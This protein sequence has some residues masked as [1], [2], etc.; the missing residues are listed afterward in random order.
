MQL[1]RLVGVAVAVLFSLLMT[2]SRAFAQADDAGA[3]PPAATPEPA[4]A[5]GSAPPAGPDAADAGPGTSSTGEPPPA[6]SASS[7]N[8]RATTEVGGYID[9]TATSVLTPSIGLV[10]ESPTA[11]WGVSGRYLVDVVSAASPDIVSTASPHWNEVRQ[12][13][14]LGARYKPGTFGIAVN[15]STSYTPDYLALSAGA[16]L[17]QELDEKNLTLIAGYGYGHD[18]IGRSRTAFSVFSRTFDYH[19]IQAGLSRIV[20]ASLVIGV[21]GDVV[22]ENGDQS[23]PYRYIPIFTPAVAATIPVGASPTVVAN[24]RLQAKPLEQLPLQRERYALTGRLA[25]RGDNGTTLRV[26]ERGYVD[27]WGL[28]ASTTDARYFI[29]LSRRW[30]IWPH[31][32]FN[33]QNSVSFWKR[34]YTANGEHDLPAL[35]TGDRELSSLFTAGGGG[36]VRVALGK[37]GSVDD[38]VLTTTIDAFY[39]SFADAIYV[40]ER[41]SALAATALEIAF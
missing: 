5:E 30:T 40:K 19:S 26:E 35:R 12:A 25:W 32:R 34:A 21:Y 24:T 16:Q 36:G 20:N 22:L 4:A 37:A 9:S 14:N 6:A 8:A 10:V 33:I 1:G 27:T 13:G 15:A 18:T 39:T 23:K 2:T 11:G 38:L 7:I 29:D 41:L 17:S 3:P 28:K 31:A